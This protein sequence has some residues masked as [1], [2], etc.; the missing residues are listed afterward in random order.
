MSEFKNVSVIKKANV[1]FDGKVSSRTVVF[2][3]GTTKTLGFMQ[4]GE[5]VFDTSKK[6]QMELLGGEWEILLPGETQWKTYT[7]GESFYVDAGVS[8]DV[9]VSDFADYCCS[10]TD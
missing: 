7:A 2:N 5:F 10:Y 3:D 8:F 9:K 1:Y 4:P 6:E